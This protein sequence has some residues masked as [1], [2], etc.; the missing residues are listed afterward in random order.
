MIVMISIFGEGTC[1]IAKDLERQMHS[2][3]EG[4]DWGQGYINKP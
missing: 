4:H 3:E 2:K 1:H